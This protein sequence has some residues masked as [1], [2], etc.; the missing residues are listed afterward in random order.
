M[1]KNTCIPTRMSIGTL[2]L[3]TTI[4]SSCDDKIHTPESTKHLE[5]FHRTFFQG[6]EDKLTD[7]G[8]NLYVDYSTCNEIGQHS[9]LYQKIGES[10]VNNTYAYYSIKGDSIKREEGE[11]YN[12]LLSIKEIPYADLVAAADSMASSNRESVMITDGEYF[13]PTIARD[14]CNNPYLYNAL[15]KWMLKGYDIHVISEPYEESYK[16]AYYRK[17]RFYIM[18]TD[19]KKQGSIYNR[20]VSTT[21]LSE[22]DGVEEFHLSASHPYLFGSGNNT[23]RQ[24]ELL[25]SKSRGFGNFEIQDWNGSDWDNTIQNM[26]VNAVDENT[27]EPLINGATVF[28]FKLDRNSFGGFKITELDL[29][30]FDINAAYASYFDST[31][32]GVKVPHEIIQYS[33]I[34][35]FMLIDSEEF[36]KHGNVQ[37][38][39]DRDWY[40]PDNLTGKPYNYFKVDV[41]VKG[42]EPTFSKYK[43]KFEFESIDKPG[44]KNVSFASSIEQCLADPEIIGMM[45]G[46]NVYTIYIKSEAE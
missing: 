43:E 24:N 34:P 15:K 6:R 40:N 42:V 28:D 9:K 13:T 3:I 22:F 27:G 16:G 39:F 26:V 4:V 30:C 32:I 7:G 29:K 46:Q 45:K 41:L 25:M 31:E 5:S 2:M 14:G 21:N 36:N 23:S 11:I 35:N 10:L 33:E 20:I 1:L 19:D 12:L 17:K 18:F 44:A 37:I 8:V 38:H